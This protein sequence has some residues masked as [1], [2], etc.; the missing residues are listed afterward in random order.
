MRSNSR[1]TDT[2]YEPALSA[3]ASTASM[4]AFG[5]YSKQQELLKAIQDAQ[6]MLS[7]ICQDHRSDRFPLLYPK[8]GGYGG[9]SLPQLQQAN[10]R[11]RSRTGTGRFQLLNLSRTP[12]PTSTGHDLSVLDESSLGRLLL[13]RLEECKEYLE[14]MMVRVKDRSS[15]VLVTGDVNGGKSTFINAL[16]RHDPPILPMDQQPCTQ[17]FC[18]VVPVAHDDTLERDTTDQ[19]LSVKAIPDYNKYAKA[20]AN[21]DTFDSM[22]LSRMQT[23]IQEEDTPYQWYIVKYWCKLV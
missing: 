23:V 4:S 3:S 2:I 18:E 8:Y 14:R 16:L 20:N 17:A 5:Y 19:V 6:S 7:T 1:S 13:G 21:N 10:T 9:D 11:S 12:T 22:S 15:R